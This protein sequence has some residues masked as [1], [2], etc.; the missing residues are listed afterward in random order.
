MIADTPLSVADLGSDDAVHVGQEDGA[1]HLSGADLFDLPPDVL[2]FL[3]SAILKDRG[4]W[5]VPLACSNKAL[6]ELVEPVLVRNATFCRDLRRF[7][8]AHIHSEVEGGCATLCE[9]AATLDWH[10]AVML[11]S[12][13]ELGVSRN[14]PTKRTARILVKQGAVPALLK[15][16]SVCGKRVAFR[17]S[18]R[19]KLIAV[20][21]LAELSRWEPELAAEHVK[22]FRRV[23]RI[24][25]V[26]AWSVSCEIRQCNFDNVPFLQ[27]LTR[28]HL[29]FAM[30]FV[31]NFNPHGCMGF[32]PVRPSAYG[33]DELIDLITSGGAHSALRSA[34]EQ[35]LRD[36]FEASE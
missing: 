24:F 30:R 22:K 28:D 36:A 5:L 34:F 6:R 3:V 10:L 14:V 16:M 15:T 21:Q 11:N 13:K 20:S 32:Q 12:V 1:A 26:L 31:E 17:Q 35:A 19:R 29:D 23:H 18:A 4:C 2:A 33:E 9:F 27:E 8:E 7:K 25:D